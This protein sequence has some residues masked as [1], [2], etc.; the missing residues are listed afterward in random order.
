MAL[1]TCILFLLFC[2]SVTVRAGGLPASTFFGGAGAD[3]AS[4]VAR[5]SD[6]SIYVAGTTFSTNLPIPAGSLDATANGGSD[7]FVAKFDSGLSNLLAATFIGGASDDGARALAID[8]AGRIV[9]AGYTYSTSFPTSVAGQDTTYNGAGDAF[10]AVLDPGLSNLIAG[11]FVGGNDYDDAFSLA[12]DGATNIYVAGT[13]GSTNFPMAGSPFDATFNGARDAFISC[14]NA[15]LSSLA[16]STLLGGNGQDHAL[17]LKWDSAGQVVVAGHTA[18]TNFPTSPGAYDAT[19]NSA[20]DLFVTRLSSNLA[21]SSASTYVGPAD[22]IGAAGLGL[23]GSGRVVVASRTSVAGYPVTLGAYDTSANGGTDIG[24]S[25]F[26]SDLST[27]IASTLLGGSDDDSLYSL[28]VEPA[29]TVCIAG[30]T[31]SPDFPVTPG[32]VDG[33][34][35]GAVFNTDAVVARFNATLTSVLAATCIRGGGGDETARS[36]VADGAGGVYIAGGTAASDFPVTPWSYDTSFNGA[37][38]GFA[39]RLSL[40]PDNQQGVDFDG[41]GRTDLVVF[42]STRLIWYLL[43][44]TGGFLQQQFGFGGVVPVQGD[45]DGDGRLD[46][47]VY[48][49][50]SGTWFIS[51]TTAGFLIQQFGFGSV[52]PVPADYDGDGRTDFA[53]YDRNSGTWYI[54]RTTEGF[55][56]R[57]FGFGS[58]LP[59]PADYDE[60]GKADLAVFDQ[61]A[62]DWYL[63]RSRAGFV[64]TQFG[65]QG[66]APVPADYDGDGQVDLAVYHRAGAAWYLL[67][68][69]AGFRTQQFGLGNVVP[70]P[71]DY[72]GDGHADI[73]VYD[74][75]TGYWRLLES[76]VGN[77]AIQFGYG[78]AVPVLNQYWVNRAFGLP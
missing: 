7:V 29:G 60:D 20:S 13:T 44:T 77:E 74:L 61:G 10:V 51:R 64:I 40:T 16:A 32:P 33:R 69:R 38:E 46:F 31:R 58:V 70:V 6:G 65:F 37:I 8:A 30:S 24:V 73:G 71:S 42:D 43:R 62:G 53:V 68:S 55:L 34:Y 35:A 25:L 14:F 1:R 12:A 27:L 4:A 22:T 72:D 59:V 56:I 9:V 67:Q 54:F 75:T 45:Y 39:G 18:S 57:Q 3:D 15:G 23:D 36:L 78:G 49:R 52:T 47:A 19:R 41:D 76:K 63:L 66:V 17:A 5:G 21:T 26:S 48:D 2:M 28:V 11:T 50:A